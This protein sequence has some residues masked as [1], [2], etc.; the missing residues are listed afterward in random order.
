LVVDKP[1][2]SGAGDHTGARFP[3]LAPNVVMLEA[4][5]CPRAS[6]RQEIPSVLL[7]FWRFSEMLAIEVDE[8]ALVNSSKASRN[9]A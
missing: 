1:G 5:K 4:F 3:E 2:I 9:E 7:K 8:P 6:W